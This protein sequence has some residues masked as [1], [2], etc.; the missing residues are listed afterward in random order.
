MQL[1]E[2]T[3]PLD[4]ILTRETPE[5]VELRFELAGP[6]A[7]GLAWLN[8]CAI[9][10]GIYILLALLLRWL[11]HL[12]WGLMSLCGFFVEWFYPVVFEATRGA[13]PG[14]RMMG[15]E[16]VREDGAPLDWT[17]ALLRNFL[18]VAD[19]LPF[20]NALGLA[21]ILIHPKM[22]RL[23]DIAAG[24]L[25]VYRRQPVRRERI[26]ERPPRPG[27]CPLTLDEQQLILDYCARKAD[28]P[29]QRAAELA[30]L[31]PELARNRYRS[32]AEEQL[33]ALGN[34]F[35][36]GGGA[37]AGTNGDGNTGDTKNASIPL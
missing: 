24:T 29:P 33:L 7:R 25:V 10:L 16:V 22:Q 36:R 21:C 35:L 17:A 23:G 26:P 14:K 1:P 8:D 18:R 34:W 19:F 12:G 2:T 28:M 20:G 37:E 11:G 15:L 3:P 13:T 5:G 31:V 27:P 32:S 6:L 9:R 30:G 4:T